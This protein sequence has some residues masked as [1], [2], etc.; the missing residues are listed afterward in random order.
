MLQKNCNGEKLFLALENLINDKNLA[1]KQISEGQ[2]AL[3]M[4]GYG[5]AQNP[6]QKAAQE[7]LKI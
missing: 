2:A 3:R 6:S 5:F 7:I 1:Q 4:K